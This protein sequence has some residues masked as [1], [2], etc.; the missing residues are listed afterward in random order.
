MDQRLE[1]IIGRI[2]SYSIY[3]PEGFSEGLKEQFKNMLSY[4]A[5]EPEDKL[6]E[7]DTLELFFKVLFELE[8]KQRPGIGSNGLGSIT[9]SWENSKT[10][11]RLIIECLHTGKLSVI[12]KNSNDQR[13]IFDGF[14]PEDLKELL[15][16]WKLQQLGIL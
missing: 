11:T 5:W 14:G 9:M 13:A 4:D 10:K 2:S 7:I 8:A 12:V 1:E 3:M 16:P 6:P 15:R